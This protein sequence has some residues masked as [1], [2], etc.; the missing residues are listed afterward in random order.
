MAHGPRHSGAQ[1]A[2]H[3]DAR[4]DSRRRRPITRHV[5][6]AAARG[7]VGDDAC[8]RASGPPFEGA[9]RTFAGLRA[10]HRRVPAHAGAQGHAA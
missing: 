6:P 1:P 4:A 7:L 10:Q 5:G 9:H 8:A 2:A 3:A